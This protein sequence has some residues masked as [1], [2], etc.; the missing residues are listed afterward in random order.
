MAIY[1]RFGALVEIISAWH[2]KN[3]PGF[4]LAKAKYL[5]AYPD[6]SGADMIGKILSGD[7]ISGG[8][9]PIYEFR[10]DDGAVEVSKACEEKKISKAPENA[11]KLLNYY[12][13]R[14]F[15]KNGKYK[16]WRKAA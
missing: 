13:P 2:P 15:D 11:S 14:L 7:K 12:W 6:G 1:N 5:S 3:H 16:D 9:L 10:A 4:F 8:W